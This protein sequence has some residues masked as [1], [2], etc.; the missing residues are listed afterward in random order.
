MLG[1]STT[2]RRVR[3]VFSTFAAV[4]AAASVAASVVAA[5][6]AT[7]GRLA[8]SSNRSGQQEIYLANA[9]G[10]DRTALGAQGNSP[11]WSPD[12]SRIAFSS[13]RD[14]NNEIYVMSADGSGQTR[15]TFGTD[16]ES[17]PQ[18]T[19]D[20]SRL[21]YTRIVGVNWEIFRMNADGS[22]QVDLTNNPA[23]EWGQAT[24]PQGT[25]IVFTR[26]ENGIGHLFVMTTDG[27]AVRRLTNTS[28]Y[29]SYPS[30]SPS[31]NLILFT[32]DPGEL[33]V[34]AS[35]GT[36]AHQITNVG[37]SRVMLNGSWSPDGMKIVYTSC[38]A[39]TLD[40]CTLSTANADA[41]SAVDVS[42]PKTPLMDTFSGAQLNHDI[43][44][45]PFA[46]GGGTSASMTQ[47]NDELEVSIPST[48]PLDP[49]LGFISIA[50][51]SQCTLAGAYDVQVDYRLLQWP[52]PV[53]VN[54]GFATN[55]S[56]FA[57]NYGM[58]VFDPGG[59]TGLSTGFPG[60]PGSNTFI[61]SVPPIGTLRLKRDG[62][63]IT[64]YRLTDTGWSAIQST[65]GTTANQ[66][67]SLDVFSNAAPGT[68]GDVKIA[69]DNLRVSSGT[70]SCPTW[71]NDS[72]AD[73][74][75]LPRS[76]G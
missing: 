72:N 37:P 75:P 47:A 65:D 52:D 18:W 53:G 24:S 31:G 40:N 12:G 20:G 45:G 17:R 54:V 11:Q 70:F 7:N 63:T 58:F 76:D 50:V 61:P 8:F 73:W 55:T 69:Y 16:Y 21:V 74:Q 10:T 36:G 25:M 4:A 41:S 43:W 64:A 42:T 57:F 1:A 6:S 3:V 26:E 28:A 19:A 14:G 34:M 13:N 44:N 56:D 71:W 49:A 22:N 29:D 15:L 35:D 48:A 46:I 66:E 9:D 30:W 23:V 59:G 2:S 5:P 39:N 27:K 33:W 32:R 60:G 68:N 51:N 67:V 62:S 38:A